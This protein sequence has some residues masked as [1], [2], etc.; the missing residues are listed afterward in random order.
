MTAI[1]HHPPPLS[2]PPNH[3]WDNQALY[4]ALNSVGITTHPPNASEWFLDI[5]ATNHMTSGSGNLHSSCPFSSSIVVENGARLP[6]THAADAFI[7]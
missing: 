6:V 7:L 3:A 1:H 4:T 2:T 5:G